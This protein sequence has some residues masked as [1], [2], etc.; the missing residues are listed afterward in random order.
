MNFEK[1]F[2]KLP[3]SEDVAGID[4]A[5]QVVPPGDALLCDDMVSIKG[6]RTPEE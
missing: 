5:V 4:E 1:I 3:L 6:L 2:R